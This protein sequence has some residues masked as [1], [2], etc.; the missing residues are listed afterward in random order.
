VERAPLPGQFL[1]DVRREFMQRLSVAL[2]G[3]LGSYLRDALQKG[4]AYVVARLPAP[5]AFFTYVHVLFSSLLV[6]S[7]TSLK[8]ISF[9]Y[10]LYDPPFKCDI[11]VSASTFNHLDRAFFLCCYLATMYTP[12]QNSGQ[13]F[14]P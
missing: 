11:L 13:D 14:A 1:K 3:A 7:T 2:H 6:N 10:R 5:R 8:L 4:R 9:T 12:L